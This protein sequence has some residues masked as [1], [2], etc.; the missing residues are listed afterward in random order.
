MMALRANTSPLVKGA[1]AK[2]PGP[3][4]EVLMKYICIRGVVT[5]AGLA[6]IGDIRELS[7]HEARVLVA[8]GKF[9]PYVEAEIETPEPAID[10]REPQ[11][12]KSRGRRG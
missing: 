10:A 7:G 5:S 1:G 12:R 4:D 9:A 2:H 11:T 6:A 3:T 8:Q